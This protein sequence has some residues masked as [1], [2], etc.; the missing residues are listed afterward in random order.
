VVTTYLS[1]GSNLGDR[2]THLHRGIELLDQPGIEV[3]RTSSTF[4]TEPVG[5]RDQAWFL[6]L[7][8]EARTSLQ[9][10]ELLA[11]CQRIEQMENRIRSFKDAPRTLDLD[12]L[13]FGDLVLDSPDLVIPHPRLAVRRFVLEP[14]AE[15]APLALHPALKTNIRSLLTRCPDRS[16]VSLFPPG[17]RRR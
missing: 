2:E 5:Y 4:E 6:N 14:L 12:I 10:H 7:V 17:E 9:P 1:A 3:A 8:I 16:T 15:L 11:A 13:L